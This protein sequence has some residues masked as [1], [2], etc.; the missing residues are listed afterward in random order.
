M[1]APRSITSKPAFAH[2]RAASVGADHQ[3]SPNFECAL[4]RCCSHAD[5]SLILEKQVVN[6]RFHTQRKR[7][8]TMRMFGNEIQ[9]VPLGH[10][11][12]EFAARRQMRKIRYR[13]FFNA[14]MRLNLA[15]L[16]MR[17]TEKHLEQA[18]FV[19]QLQGRRMYRV[20]A[21]IA[22]KIFVLF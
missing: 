14:K 9:K 15:E 4:R 12:D 22:Q 5:D 10:E 17:A 13:R 8:A 18:E 7:G 6:R 1:G 19:H 16:L 20:A 2:R 21:K 3:I 11:G